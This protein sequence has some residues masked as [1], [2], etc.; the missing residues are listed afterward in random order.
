MKLRRKR[1]GGFSLLELIVV[2]VVVLIVSAMALP[3]FFNMIYNIR[4]RS[5]AQTVAGMMQ[6]CRMQA[7]RDNTFYFVRTKLIGNA[8]YVWVS[9]SLTS[10]EPQ[11]GEPQA[12]LGSGVVSATSPPSEPSVGF[13]TLD[14][15]LNKTPAFNARGLPCFS[16][17][18]RCNTQ[19][20]AG[21]GSQNV[22]FK[23]FLTD[24]RPMGA[25][26]WAAVMISPA[27]RVQTFQYYGSGWGQ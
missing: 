16:G 20:T 9:K 26:G 13:P 7:V 2:V 27:G 15:A 25:N 23:L 10:T 21:S 22:G 8:T 12:V 14:F 1:E 24:S 5:S 17:G 4:L 3:S 19:F 18:A 6:T 11:S